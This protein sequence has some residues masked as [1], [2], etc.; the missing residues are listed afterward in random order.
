MFDFG[1]RFING[2]PVVGG[3][4]SNLWGDPDQEAMQEAFAKAKQMQAKS[5]AYAM[6]GRMN[7]MNQSALAFGPRNQ[8]LGEMMGKGPGQNAMDLAPMLKNPMPQQQQQDIRDAAFA[9]AP[10]KMSI[11]EQAIRKLGPYSGGR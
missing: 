7:A 4:T 2:L 9:P 3:I 5:R 1:R 6:D 8:M 10:S 11:A